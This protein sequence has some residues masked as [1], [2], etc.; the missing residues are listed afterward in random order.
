MFVVYP[1]DSSQKRSDRKSF[2]IVNAANADDARSRC[3]SM[4]GDV[5]GAMS[6]WSAIEL[7]DSSNFD[8]VVETHHGPVGTSDDGNVWPKLTS[9]GDRLAI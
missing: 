3:E 7:T 2:F 5:A 4:V 6:G 8:C 1:S 9:G